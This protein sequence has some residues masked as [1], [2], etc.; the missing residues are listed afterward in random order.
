MDV[1]DTSGMIIKSIAVAG[2]AT[3]AKVGDLVYCNDSD[4]AGVTLTQPTTDYPIGILHRFV[5]VTDCDIK[6]YTPMEHSLGIEAG[7]GGAT[8]WA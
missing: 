8:G 7:I 2:T 4:L 6:L 5:S 3:Q 1:V